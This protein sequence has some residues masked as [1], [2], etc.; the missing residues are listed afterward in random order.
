MRYE[1]IFILYLIYGFVY[2]FLGIVIFQVKF[3]E[4]TGFSFM[5]KLPLL[6]LFGF[7]HG[8]SEWVTLL[9]VSSL[10]NSYTVP[11]TLLKELLKVA[12]FY[13]LLKFS[14]KLILDSLSLDRS[15]KKTTK[16]LL[17][18]PTLLLI[19]W[20]VQFLYFI[21]F[22]GVSYYVSHR[23]L[24]IIIMRY[25][26]ALPAGMLGF[27]GFLHMG[28]N[29][30]NKN[31][32]K[33]GVWFYGLGTTFF[34]YG[35]IDGLFVRKMDFFPANFFHHQLFFQLTGLPIQSIKI[36][37][38][39]LMIFH[40][41]KI[42]HVFEARKKLII[43]DRFSKE[44]IART[45]D[46]MNQEIHDHI[47]QKMFG[48]SLKIDAFLTTSHED[49]L[50][51]AQEDLK[52]GISE[53]RDI[54]KNNTVEIFG[55]RDLLELINDIIQ[56]K[57]NET[58][59]EITVSNHIPP[60][61]HGKLTRTSTRQICYILQEALTNSIKHSQGKTLEISLADTDDFFILEISDDGIGFDPTKKLS[62]KE[63]EHMGI[64]IMKKR[65]QDID[66]KISI[67]SDHGGVR[68]Q[69][70]KKWEAFI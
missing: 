57:K 22:H 45:K 3:I 14:L 47:I 64:N 35:I 62:S 10:Y 52:C 1:T 40:V 17:L 60:F 2:I 51:S 16:Y 6:G 43:E 23:T 9:Q 29:T 48:A 70:K 54:I 44:I 12:S 18:I 25:F 46:R 8:L 56:Q 69:L 27:V 32:M 15:T 19:L 41:I 39:S 53:A 58:T 24:S 13:F 7:F 36:L 50:L 21:G 65:A 42:I 26:M 4:L 11:L 63:T 59:L 49:Y 20:I 30:S 28:L 61:S 38:G 68:I 34:L 66:G 33:I 37:I 31:G 55:S 67:I 5:K